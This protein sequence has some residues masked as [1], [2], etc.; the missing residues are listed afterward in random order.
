MRRRPNAFLKVPGLGEICPRPP[1]LDPQFRFD[2]VPP[3]FE[4]AKEAFGVRRMMWGSDFPPSAG[5]EG[6]ANTLNGVMEHP[7]FADGDDKEWVVGRTAARRL[8]IRPRRCL[9]SRRKPF[10]V[11]LSN[12]E[13]RPRPFDRLTLRQAQGERKAF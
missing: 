10:V 5:R 13:Q 1:R 6:Y 8:G 11:S 12:H 9:I 7:A 4:M 2:D 3:L